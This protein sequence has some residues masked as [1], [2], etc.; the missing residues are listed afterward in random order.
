MYRTYVYHI[1]ILNENLEFLEN[2]EVLR[3]DTMYV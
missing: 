3:F 1:M 2:L